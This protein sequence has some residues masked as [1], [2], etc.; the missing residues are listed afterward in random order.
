MAPLENWMKLWQKL[1]VYF[2]STHDLQWRLIF[3][4]Q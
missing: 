2:I 4:H 3:G 1:L